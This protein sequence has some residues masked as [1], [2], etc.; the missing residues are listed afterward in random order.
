[1]NAW[2]RAIIRHPWLTLAIILGITVFFAL[3]IPKIRIDN[4][5]TTF[6]PDHHPARQ[7]YLDAQEIFGSETVSLIGIFLEEDS[8]A[9]TVF[10]PELLTMVRD[11]T[12]ECEQASIKAP[13]RN[14]E[15]QK[16]PDGS[17]LWV[18]MGSEVKTESPTDVISLATMAHVVSKTVPSEFPDED[19]EIVIEVEDMLPD[20]PATLKT[21]QEALAKLGSYDKLPAEL[22]YNEKDAKQAHRIIDSWDMYKNNI[23][24]QDL[25]STAIYITLPEGHTI[26][27]ETE[28]HKFLEEMIARYDK[29]NDGIAFTL[30]GLPTISSL[31][32]QY[33]HRDLRML[34][35]ICFA[36]MVLILL[37]S[38]RRFNGVFMPFITVGMSVIWT[39]GLMAMLGKAMT[40]ITSGLPVLL[41][42]VGSAYTIHV[43]HHF[44]DQMRAGAEKK[45]AIT[46]TM[47]KI[48]AA[49]LMAGLTTVGGFGSLMSSEVVPI[50]EYGE[51]AAFGAFAAL[52]INFI[53]VPAA[54]QIQPNRKRREDEIA[55]NDLEHAEASFL[56]R[57]LGRLAGFVANNP[58]AV[59]LASLL[60]LIGFS[61]LSSFMVTDSNLVEYFK[62][63]SPI[64][65]SDRWLNER[66]GGTTT[67]SLVVD[68]KEPEGFMKP[69][70]LRKVEALQAFLVERFPDYIKKTMSVADYV[71]KINKTIGEENPDQFRIPD[72]E[73]E[74]YENLLLYES[75]PEVLEKVIDFDRQQVRVLVKA[76]V[77]G[78]RYM[79][80]MKPE[81]DAW[82]ATNMPEFDVH[83]NGEMFLRWNVDQDLVA[84]QK[85]SI[86]ISV[87][88]VF[89]LLMLIFK[90]A[91]VG[92]MAMSPIVLSILGNFS[93]MVLIGYSLDIGTALIA[94]TAVGIGID[95][96]IHYVNR[97][98]LE[99]KD[100]GPI[101]A[102]RRTHIST[103]KAIVFNAFAVAIGFLVLTGSQFIPL[104]RMGLLSAVTMF[105]A[106]T[107][108]L[109][110]LPAL[111]I[112][113]KPYRQKSAEEKKS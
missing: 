35:P 50:R 51:F 29:E 19:P 81:I 26:E 54:L 28:L 57:M 107:A 10:T 102:V 100:F 30:A 103:G 67:F 77:G 21:R 85:R 61:V 32:G 86:L 78:T 64:R 95:Y 79:T 94:S 75:K 16:Q 42:A 12:T 39:V 6:L 60:I 97:Y 83:F 15:R 74:V 47:T 33:M 7:Y 106:A 93:I 23:V 73:A 63:D 45:Q 14:R 68:S 101:E 20:S 55:E 36:V 22:L 99:R 108:T 8:P 84:G 48:G 59:S 76:M 41:V 92:L 80:E 58:K 53:F 91:R 110:T 49:V 111:L 65:V 11:I 18:E 43:I 4:E 25:R 71:K 96:A 44:Y 89:F 37:I 5:L 3:Q 2:T 56:G 40:V 98:R 82:C 31:L 72:S 113:T 87:I 104:I 69:E 66:L 17:M 112:V 9:K 105:F 34:V 24:G 62:Y 27:Y 46:T 52:V 1:M 90:S 70:N 13:I 109:I 38:F 88:A